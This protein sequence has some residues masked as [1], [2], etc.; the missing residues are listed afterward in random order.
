MILQQ[1]K[2]RSPGREGVYLAFVFAVQPSSVFAA[3]DLVGCGG[4]RDVFRIIV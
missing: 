2:Q 4:G 1:E 3:V